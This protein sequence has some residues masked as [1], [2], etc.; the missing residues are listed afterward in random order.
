MITLNAGLIDQISSLEAV[1]TPNLLQQLR[2]HWGNFLWSTNA[3][4][5]SPFKAI[6]TAGQ[7]VEDVCTT[8]FTTTSK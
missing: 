1:L 6:G 2:G 4:S 3:T 7:E 8:I 5:A